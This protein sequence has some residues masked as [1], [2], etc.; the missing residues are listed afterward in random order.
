M[1]ENNQDHSDANNN[2]TSGAGNGANQRGGDESVNISMT[3]SSS[4][5]PPAAPIPGSVGSAL[6]AEGSTR[7]GQEKFDIMGMLPLAV[8]FVVFYFFMIR[9]QAKKQK[10]HN[11][12]LDSLQRGDKLVTASGMVGTVSRLDPDKNYV[13]IE[14]SK[15]VIVQIT[16]SSIAQI[17][18]SKNSANK[19]NIPAV[20]HSKKKTH[21]KNKKKQEERAEPKTGSKTS[22]AKEVSNE[23]N[24]ENAENAEIK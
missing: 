5:T 10:E 13:H 4:D 15:D 9:P 21:N 12:L 7:R 24:E 18:E 20:P 1:T 11:K 3:S 17:L 2:A 14:I 8:I 16:R 23:E 6:G 19:T 22:N